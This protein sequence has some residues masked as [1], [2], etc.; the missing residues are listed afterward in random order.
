MQ[1]SWKVRLPPD[2]PAFFPTDSPGFSRA[3]P[4][5]LPWCPQVARAGGSGSIRV[6]PLGL[7]S[8]AGTP[9]SVCPALYALQVV[10]VY[11]IGVLA[12]M[13]SCFCVNTL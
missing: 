3:P 6:L 7:R 8:L 2:P 4:G 1:Q 12:S 9:R 10:P 5:V 13:S 11:W